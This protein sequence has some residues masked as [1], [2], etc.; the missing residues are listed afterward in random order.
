MSE[1]WIGRLG[2]RG[3]QLTRALVMKH[4]P[5]LTM[6]SAPAVAKVLEGSDERKV[7]RTR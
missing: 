6:V 7:G 1:A 5:V 2:Q 3:E 4:A